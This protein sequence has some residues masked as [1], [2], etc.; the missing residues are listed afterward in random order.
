MDDA[1]ILVVAFVLDVLVGALFLWIGMKVTAR[2]V[3]MQPGASY[4]S[5]RH[6]FIVVA[7]AA[8][9]GLLPGAIGWI[10]SFV[11]LFVLLRKFTDA[12]L[13]ELLGMVVISR[14]AAALVGALL[15]PLD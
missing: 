8:A 11:V 6:L 10:A 2:I 1:L 4:C 3:G 5:F 7:C 14:L 9:A 12:G 13:W 15:L